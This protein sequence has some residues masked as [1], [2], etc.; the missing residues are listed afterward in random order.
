MGEGSAGRALD[1]HG[2]PPRWL[3]LTLS[4]RSGIIGANAAAHRNVSESNPMIEQP[5]LVALRFL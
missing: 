1:G 5:R 3:S 4:T 2:T